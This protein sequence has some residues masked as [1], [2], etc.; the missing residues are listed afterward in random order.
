VL[1]QLLARRGPSLL[2]ALNGPF[3][4]ARYEPTTHRLLL[5]RDRVGKK[6]LYLA[7]TPTGWAFASTLA[8]LH[9]ATGSLRIRP[10]AIHE[11][12]VFR[13]VGGQHSAFAGV[14]QVPPGTWLELDANGILR[15]GRYWRSP[16]PDDETVSPDWV[17]EVIDD[18]VAAR[19][20]GSCELG[21]F[22]SGG[23]DSAVVAASLR[24]QRPDQPLRLVSVGYDVAG[25]EDERPFALRLGAAMGARHDQVIVHGER[26][27]PELMV[28]AAR[29]LEDPVQDPVTLPT[30]ALA[31]VAATFT[32]VILTGDGSDELWG[33]YQRFSAPP[34]ELTDYWPRTAIF[35]PEELGL[36]AW[37]LTY[38]DGVDL[39][40][41]L[42]DP[43]DRILRLEFA[44]RLRNYHLSRIDKLV[45]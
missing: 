5:A 26:D 39:P 44:N 19:A 42:T 31:R 18:A 22:L 34:V 9:V 13:S 1:A 36:A 30:L 11:H 41:M 6:P 15:G 32:R 14:E 29:L 2:S 7:Q 45:P 23:L 24:R 21:V 25:T 20:D 37:P 43:L 8:A 10:D 4:L 28:D 40:A 17:R 3:A 16:P 38:L 33:G 12:L 27:V 35:R